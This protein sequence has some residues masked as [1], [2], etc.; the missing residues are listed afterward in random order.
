M[1]L[2]QLF[3]VLWAVWLH[4]GVGGGKGGQ[5]AEPCLQSHD[6]GELGH[7]H[8]EPLGFVHLMAENYFL[9]NLGDISVSITSLAAD[10]NSQNL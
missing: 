8:I 7:V 10:Y 5:L 6:G 9:L 3:E 1:K 4:A 2:L